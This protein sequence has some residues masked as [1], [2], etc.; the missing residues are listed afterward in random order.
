MRLFAG[1]TAETWLQSVTAEVA[2]ACKSPRSPKSCA[3]PRDLLRSWSAVSPPPIVHPRPP[4]RRMP[5]TRPL[6]F[7]IAESETGAPVWLAQQCR[8]GTRHPLLNKLAVPPC[9]GTHAFLRFSRADF[10]KHP[11]FR[12]WL[13]ER[14]YVPINVAKDSKSSVLRDDECQGSFNFLADT[15]C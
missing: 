4:P 2:V 6:H 15:K 9:R 3:K 13:I 11:F 7:Q 10:G 8:I 12:G 5:T 14:N 1:S